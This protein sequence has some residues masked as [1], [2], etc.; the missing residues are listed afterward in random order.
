MNTGETV[1]ASES[2][3]EE[4]DLSDVAVEEDIVTLNKRLYLKKRRIIQTDSE[5]GEESA[6]IEKRKKTVKKNPVSGLKAS[7]RV[8]KKLT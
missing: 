4:S 6:C 7:N 5:D 1:E 8:R 2:L 3:P